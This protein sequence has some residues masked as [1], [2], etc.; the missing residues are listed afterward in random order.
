MELLWNYL[1]GK[2]ELEE[3]VIITSKHSRIY[4][5]DLVKSIPWRIEAIVKQEDT[6]PS[7]NFL[8]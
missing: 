2:S 4:H 7:P 6:Q 8:Y 1:N 3:F 5:W